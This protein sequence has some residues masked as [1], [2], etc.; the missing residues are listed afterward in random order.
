[1][2]AELP[3][4]NTDDIPYENDV[5]SAEEMERDLGAARW[6]KTSWCSWRSPRGLLYLGPRPAW[7]VMTGA[8]PIDRCITPETPQ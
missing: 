4:P 6:I 1:M 2:S 3:P 5:P 8:W 7:L